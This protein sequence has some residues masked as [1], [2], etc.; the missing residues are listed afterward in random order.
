MSL[1]SRLTHRPE[2]V[3]EFS[4]VAANFL[5]AQQ[6]RRENTVTSLTARLEEQ[7]RLK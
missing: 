5:E 4:T 7:K 1:M 3:T 6:E 2:I